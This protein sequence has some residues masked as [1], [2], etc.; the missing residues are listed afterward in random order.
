[1][2]VCVGCHLPP[3]PCSRLPFNTNHTQWPLEKA[4]CLLDLR[5]IPTPP[6]ESPD[7]GAPRRPNQNQSHRCSP[8]GCSV[9]LPDSQGLGGLSAGP[10]R[11]RRAPGRPP[12]EWPAASRK[13]SR[14]VPVWARG[15]ASQ[16][17]NGETPPRLRCAPYPPPLKLCPG[18][19][20]EGER[21]PSPLAQINA[22]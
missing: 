1:M 19:S 13:C 22:S 3:Y 2:V 4:Q 7:S 10:A 21:T 20:A 8:C 16:R 12:S 6:Q 15:D 9:D 14:P 17:E 5:R 11:L 18:L